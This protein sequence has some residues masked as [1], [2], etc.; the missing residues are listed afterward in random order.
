MLG[1][2]NPPCKEPFFWFYMSVFE[3]VW[4]WV[5]QDIFCGYV[6]VNDALP[7][8]FFEDGLSLVVTPFRFFVE[9][10]TTTMWVRT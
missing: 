8:I 2:Q 6:W 4:G 7:V 1:F 5:G 3:G 10:M 9:V